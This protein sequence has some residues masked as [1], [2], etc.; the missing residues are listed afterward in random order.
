MSDNRLRELERVA[1]EY[2]TPDNRLAYAAEA[3]R[4][5][6]IFGALE[7]FISILN[8]RFH[9]KFGSWDHSIPS[10]T[11]DEPGQK[12]IRIVKSDGGSRSCYCFV[13]LETGDVYKSKNWKAPDTKHSRGSIYDIDPSTFCGPYGI[14]YMNHNICGWEPGET[15]TGPNPLPAGM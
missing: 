7:R 12:Y 6:G 8:K 3:R 4:S 14:A 15:I 11:L 10:L 1:L 9:E 13:N 5:A 2:P